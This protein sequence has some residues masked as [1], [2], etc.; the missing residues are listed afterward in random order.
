MKNASFWDIIVCGDCMNRH[1][2]GTQRL[3]HKGD[4]NQ[5]SCFHSHRVFLPSVRQLL[6]TANIVP[7][8]P[9][10]VTLMMEA[11]RSSET[12]VRIKATWCNIP[13][14]TIL[15]EQTLF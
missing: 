15:H 8:S 12:S 3:H 1:F 13:E 7:S 6:G 2:G 5:Y 11:L 9:I 14:D 10:A 4:K